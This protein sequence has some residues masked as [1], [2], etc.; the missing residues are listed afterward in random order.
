M[1]LTNKNNP[2]T[3][4]GLATQPVHREKQPLP[5][6]QSIFFFIDLTNI[7][8]SILST[9]PKVLYF[10]IDLINI[11]QSILSTLPKVLYFVIDIINIVQSILSTL[12]K[13]LNFV[14]DLIN[15]AQSIVF[16]IDLISIVMSFSSYARHS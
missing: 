16:F 8:Q 12:P 13:V 15:I 11:V 6:A 10:F 3:I 9:L 5:A 1:S 4:E 7:V 2:R 14:I